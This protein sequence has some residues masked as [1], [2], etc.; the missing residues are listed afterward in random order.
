VSAKN[1]PPRS[2]RGA[3][4]AVT[5]P[6]A[7]RG[8]DDEQRSATR[9][10]PVMCCGRN[11]GF[12]RFDRMFLM[13]MGLLRIA[14]RPEEIRRICPPPS[15]MD[16]SSSTVEVISKN[17]KKKKKKNESHSSEKGKTQKKT[18]KGKNV[19]RSFSSPFR[20]AVNLR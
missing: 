4:D 12:S 6:T 9:W 18:Q 3:I 16:P 11:P 8:A 7:G 17:L 10:N 20:R 1:S 2:P 5:S 14:E 13:E 15:R 19:Q